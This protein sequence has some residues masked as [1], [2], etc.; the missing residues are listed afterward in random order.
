MNKEV[1][2]ISVLDLI[3]RKYKEFLVPIGV[4]LACVV[5]FFIVVIPQF[6]SYLDKRE[7]VK[8]VRAR[9]EV[10][11]SNVSVLSGI[12]DGQQDIDFQL[13]LLGIPAEKDYAGIIT[14]ISQASSKTGVGIDDYQFQVGPLATQSAKELTEKLFITFSLDVKGGTSDL[15]RFVP[16][17]YSTLPLS[18]VSEFDS[19]PNFSSLSV[20]FYYKPLPVEDFHLDSALTPLTTNER[21]LLDQLT[22][23]QESGY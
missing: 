8:Q 3:K 22:S 11:K 10:L 9:I 12:Q 5:V 7:E 15:A 14:A 21:L 1:V 13:S 20:A 17:L 4:M 18:K 2:S 23:F 6:Q 16:T 19:Q